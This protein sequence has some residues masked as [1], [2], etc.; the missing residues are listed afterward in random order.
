MDIGKK[1]P[2][3]FLGPLMPLLGCWVFYEWERRVQLERSSICAG[4]IGWGHGES[5]VRFQKAAE[6]YR[7]DHRK[8]DILQL[9]RY[10]LA[11]STEFREF[12]ARCHREWQHDL[13]TSDEYPG[14]KQLVL[15]LDWNNYWVR[16]TDDG[17]TE[18]RFQ[19]PEE[20]AR[21]AAAEFRQANDRQLLL[22]FPF[23]CRQWLDSADPLTEEQVD[24]IW[25]SLQVI[26]H[27]SQETQ[28]SEALVPD[29]TPHRRANGLAAGAAA[30]A[31][32][33]NALLDDEKTAFCRDVF[34]DP[35]LNEPP[36]RQFDVDKAVGNDSWDYFLTDLTIEYLN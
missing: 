30:L 22:T 12:I 7:A 2:Q 32:L 26:R 25:Q 23:Q 15:A 20:I 24:W 21:Q 11:S 5:P 33:G 13:Q 16:T 19:L 6:W 3:L 8:T 35:L 18:V 34:E 31:C 9:A 10:L 27:F 14:L 17:R 36:R 28:Q 4:L 29:D 1:R